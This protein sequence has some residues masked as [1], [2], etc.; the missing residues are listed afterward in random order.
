MFEINNLRVLNDYLNQTI[1]V[2][3]RAQRL[4]VIPG[5]GLSH[6]AFGVPSFLGAIPGAGGL[7]MDPTVAGLAHS[8]FLGHASP[9]G[10]AATFGAAAFGGSP[11]TNAIGSFAPNYAG[12]VD[13]FNAQRGLNHSAAAFGNNPFGNN[14]FANN[15]WSPFAEIARQQQIATALAARTQLLEAMV[16]GSNFGI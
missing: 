2:L 13:P 6:S 5:A 12:V 10:G 3:V 11:F 8:P 9:F 16:R 14:V 15:P 7:G 1:D 4:G